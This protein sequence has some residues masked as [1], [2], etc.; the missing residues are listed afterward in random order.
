MLWASCSEWVAFRT[1]SLGNLKCGY[2]LMLA[3]EFGQMLQANEARSTEWWE[4]VGDSLERERRWR[5][6]GPG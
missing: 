4:E 5:H 2:P 1:G 6:L 3:P